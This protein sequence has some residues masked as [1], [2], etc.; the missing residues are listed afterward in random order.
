MIE[1]ICDITE[2]G[3]IKAFR[4]FRYFGTFKTFDELSKKCDENFGKNNYRIS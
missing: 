4:G 1:I 3:F 2:N